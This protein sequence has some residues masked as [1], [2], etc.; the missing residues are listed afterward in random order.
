MRGGWWREMF[1]NAV[2]DFFFA[3]GNGDAQALVLTDSLSCC[4]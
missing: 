4:G 1:L 3:V 2:D